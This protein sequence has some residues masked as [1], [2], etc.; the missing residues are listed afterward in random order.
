MEAVVLIL[1]GFFDFLFL[2]YFFYSPHLIFKILYFFFF[3]FL[4]N[5]LLK[6][7]PL[8]SVYVPSKGM[9]EIEYF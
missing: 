7:A 9:H 1:F 4:C 6:F 8:L 2:F 5:N 3:F